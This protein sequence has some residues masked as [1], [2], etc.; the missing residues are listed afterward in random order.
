MPASVGCAVLGVFLK[1]LR[2]HV[3]VW[4]GASMLEA[5]FFRCFLVLGCLLVFKNWR[6]KSVL[7]AQRMGLFDRELL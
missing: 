3:F 6:L 5:S 1:P 4:S 2:L 7:E